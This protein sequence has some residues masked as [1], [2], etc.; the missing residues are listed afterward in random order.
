MAYIDFMA[1][2]LD[3]IALDCTGMPNN[4]VVIGSSYKGKQTWEPHINQ[5]VVQEN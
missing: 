2:L 4:K 5:Y 3:Q 1:M